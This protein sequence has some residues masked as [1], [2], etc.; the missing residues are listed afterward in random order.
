MKVLRPFIITLM[1]TAVAP[2]ALY[3]QTASV[4]SQASEQPN[5]QSGNDIIVTALLQKS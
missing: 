2:S 5:V 3:A 1:S 4:P